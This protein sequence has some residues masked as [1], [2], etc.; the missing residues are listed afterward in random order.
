MAKEEMTLPEKLERLIV[1]SQQV[2]VYMGGDRRVTNEQYR[3]I[4]KDE[5]KLR[6]ELFA[7]LTRL[8]NAGKRRE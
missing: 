8:E 5:V 4:C 7:I 2:V 3:E 6:E 1:R